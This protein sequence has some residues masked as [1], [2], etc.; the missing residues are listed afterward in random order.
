[1]NHP[2]VTIN[3]FYILVGLKKHLECDTGIRVC[4]CNWGLVVHLISL[5]FSTTGSMRKEG[6]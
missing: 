1:M 3:F 6:V 2:H 4:I 5:V